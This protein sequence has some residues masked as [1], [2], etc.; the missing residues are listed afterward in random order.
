M[1][2]SSS[3]SGSSA[4]ISNS[5]TTTPP[6]KR[7]MS[8]PNATRRIKCIVLSA[9]TLPR[10]LPDG[11]Q[12]TDCKMLVKECQ[13]VSRGQAQRKFQYMRHQE[14]HIRKNLSVWKKT[15]D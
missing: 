11:K 7:D 6:R 2:Q 3:S 14:Q 1:I 8:S 9:P 12:S 13:P 10:T 15:H 4:V 5:R